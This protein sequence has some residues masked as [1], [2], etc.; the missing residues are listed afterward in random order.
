MNEKPRPTIFIKQLGY[1]IVLPPSPPPLPAMCPYSFDE[2]DYSGCVAN[3]FFPTMCRH[4]M[5][6]ILVYLLK[7]GTITDKLFLPP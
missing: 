2:A 1:L 6:E 4:N 3:I 7:G 5:M